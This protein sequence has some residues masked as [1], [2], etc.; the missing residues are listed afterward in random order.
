MDRRRNVRDPVW[1]EIEFT[2]IEWAVVNTP[3]FQRLRRIHQLALTMLVFPGA[4]HSR[5]GHSL[6]TLSVASRLARR[7]AETCDGSLST[8]EVEVVRLA[9]LLHDVGHGPF[10]HVGDVFLNRGGHEG[11]EEIGASI[12]EQDEHLAKAVPAEVLKAVA[13]LIRKEGARTVARD[14][15][16]GPAD[17]DKADYL[18][19]DSY[20]AGVNHGTFDV[21]RLIDQA[22]VV[23]TGKGQTALGFHVSGISAVEGMRLA[24][25]QMHRTVYG[26]RNRLVTDYMLQRGIAD[27]LARE[28]LPPDLLTIPSKAEDWPSF[29]HQYAQWDDWRLMSVLGESNGIAGEMFS[30]LRDHRL[31]KLLVYVEDEELQESLGMVAAAAVAKGRPTEAETIEIEAE[32]A[33]DL[34][35]GPDQVIV[36]VFDPKHSFGTPGDPASLDDDDIVILDHRNRPQKFTA[37][38]EV[39]SQR[40]A[41]SWRRKLLVY[42]LNGRKA[43]EATASRIESLT[44]QLLRER[45]Q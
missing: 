22:T 36:R 24:R 34:K 37:R 16:S 45:L 42:S 27:A 1:G 18:M 6:G 30:R 35:I 15:V 9:A 3:V 5:F 11:H 32:I 14:I 38:S 20:F 44:L 25:H 19:R 26:H 7:V 21:D 33:A 2:D 39:F 10:S 23:D 12:I 29:L 31:F 8:E 28:K 4:T 40:S 41:P 17:A 43:D 13:S